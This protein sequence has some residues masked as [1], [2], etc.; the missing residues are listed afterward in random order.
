MAGGWGSESQDLEAGAAGA[1]SG[2][3]PMQVSTGVVTMYRR[4]CQ[5]APGVAGLLPLCVKG[6]ARDAGGMPSC[7]Q[8]WL[9]PVWRRAQADACAGGGALLR[10]PGHWHGWSAEDAAVAAGAVF[11]G[12]ARASSRRPCSSPDDLPL[13]RW[14]KR[15][16]PRPL[17]EV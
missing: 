3:L 10:Q 4:R 17:P 6:P 5:A 14:N 11:F 9:R 8:A 16:C 7:N 12:A 2:K 13:S 15:W 1:A